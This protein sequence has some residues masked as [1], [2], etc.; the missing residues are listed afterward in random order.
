MTT[1]EIARVILSCGSRAYDHHYVCTADWETDHERASIA[2]ADEWIDAGF[3]D[4]ADV[5]AWFAAGAFDADC[6]GELRDAGLT[7]ASASAV[8]VAL[9]GDDADTSIAYAHSSGDIS[10]ADA[11]ELAR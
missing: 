7:A 6:A 1:N 3:T 8:K 2:T 4:A 5:V 9:H 10:T 11:V